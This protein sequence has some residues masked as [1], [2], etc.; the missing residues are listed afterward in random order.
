[1]QPPAG[2]DVAQDSRVT[3][4]WSDGPEQVPE[5]VGLSEAEAR[6]RIEAAGFEVSVVND[7]TTEAERGTVLQQAPPA[8]Q[9]AAE[10]STVTIVVSTFEEPSESPSPTPSET[11]SASPTEEPSP[12]VEPPTP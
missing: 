8:G 3:L 4:F 10:G 5:V 2:T 12:S 7:S 9:D 11:P 6:R 1:M